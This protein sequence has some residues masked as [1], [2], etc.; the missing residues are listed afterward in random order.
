MSDVSFG[1]SRGESADCC[2][3][4]ALTVTLARSRTDGVGAATRRSPAPN[5]VCGRRAVLEVNTGKGGIR[6]ATRGE[7]PP[8][9]CLRF[10]SC[11]ACRQVLRDRVRPEGESEGPSTLV[12]TRGGTGV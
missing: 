2:L 8:V 6:W 10:E 11:V 5:P 12:P 4:I 9:V 7:G 1:V 3:P